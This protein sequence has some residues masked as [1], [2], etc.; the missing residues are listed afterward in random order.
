MNSGIASTVS[1]LSSVFST[2]SGEQASRDKVSEE[3]SAQSEL[4]FDPRLKLKTAERNKRRLAFVDQGVYVDL[5][6]KLRAKSK[7]QQLQQEIATISKKTGI[8]SDSRL[9]L[10]QPKRVSVRERERARVCCLLEYLDGQRGRGYYPD[11]TLT[12]A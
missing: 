5:A 4:F 6:N 8:S 3:A 12:I 10:I 9:A 11:L 2:V 1:G 7:L